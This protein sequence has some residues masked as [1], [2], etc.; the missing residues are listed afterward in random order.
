MILCISNVLTAWLLYKHFG[1][2]KALEKNFDSMFRWSQYLSSRVNDGI[3]NDS[4]IGDWAPPVNQAIPGSIGT[5]SVSAN[6]P[7]ALVSTAHYINM[8]EILSK[9]ALVLK[10]EQLSKELLA[11][12]LVCKKAFHQ[13]FFN[14]DTGGYGSNNQACNSMALYMDIVPNDLRSRVLENLVSDIVSNEYHLTTGNL[15]TKYIFDVLA[16]GGETNIAFK[17]LT[18]T[19][20]PSWG[21]MLEKG[22]TTMWERWEEAT[23]KGMNS[24]NH[25]MYASIGSWFYKYLA[26]IKLPDTSVGFSDLIIEPVFP[27]GL[28]WVRA[29]LDTIRGR[30]QYLG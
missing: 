5:S 13:K 8:L 18:Q 6:T 27:T 29:K 11:E 14:P 3:L 23:G 9:I 28:D 16:D 17:L 20:Y 19:S 7:G 30:Y 22:A 21:Y 4:Y 10:N 25:A 15:A 12:C 26:G 24:H 2:K 1:N